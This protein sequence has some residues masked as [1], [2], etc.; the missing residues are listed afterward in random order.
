MK[1]NLLS[2]VM[3]CFATSSVI[4]AQSN[5]EILLDS[6]HKYGITKC[7]A[8]ILKNSRL[9]GNANLFIN[10]HK[11]GID[12]PSTEVSIITIYGKKGDSVKVDDSYIQTAKNCFLD[13]R[14]TVTNSGS[15]ESNIDSNYWQVSLK[16]P[17]K[18]Y[19]TYK[20]RYGIE[21]QA[22]E[23]SVG[24]LKACI[25]ETSIRI[26]KFNGDQKGKK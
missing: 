16:M 4:F 1:K 5:E 12:G 2:I 18:D 25:K 13:S 14:S 3:I 23:I 11:G 19:T 8:F 17:D 21:M 20:N 26:R 22:K 24:D 15:C 10:K 9:E 6:F 7:D